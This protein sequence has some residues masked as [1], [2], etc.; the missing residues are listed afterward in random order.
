MPHA[1]PARFLALARLRAFALLAALAAL[2]PLARAAAA[3]APRPNLVY[4]LADDLGFNDCGF[5]GGKEIPTPNLDRLAASG[6][7]LDQF[8]VQPV[9]SPTRAAFMTGRYPFRYGLQVGVVRPYAPYGLALD[10]RLLP[11]AL[12]EAGYE[13]AIVGKWHL[14]HLSPAY[15]PT[16]R[17]FDHQY[18]HYN[19]ALDYFTH[20][21]DGGHDWHRDDQPNYDEGYSTQLV[22]RE[23]SRLIR[24]RDRTKPLFLYVPFNAVHAPWQAPQETIDAVKNLTANRRTYAAMLIELDRAVGEII[25]TLEKENLLSNTLIV[26]SSDNGGPR[27]GVVTDNTPLRAGK[28]TLYEGG[29]RVA[30]CASWPGRIPAGSRIG[31]PLHMVDWYPTMLGLAG[32]SL[33]Q[34]LPLDGRDILGCLT[35]GAPSPHEVIVFNTTPDS[36]ALREGRWKLVRN[37]QIN[38]SD[39]EAPATTTAQKKGKAKSAKQAAR[40]SGTD[41]FELFDLDADP[42]E[43]TNLAAAHP[44]IV[45]RLAARLAAFNAAAA[46]PLSGPNDNKGTAPKIWGQFDPKP[47]AA[48]KPD[49][50]PAPMPGFRAA[51]PSPARPNLVVFLSDD[52]SLLDSSVYGSKDVRTPN[53]QRLATDGLTF[54][55]AF[56]ASPSC[57]PSRA[58]L[59]TGLMPARNGAEPNHS[60]PRADI[61]KLPAYLQE[62]GYEVVAF[63]KVSH[64]KHT[65]DYGFDFFAHDA[66][67]EDI[68]VSAA[69]KWLRARTSTKP[70]CFIV[71]TNWPHVPWPKDPEGND[72]TKLLVPPQHVDTVQTRDARAR[73]Y[74]AIGRMDTELGEVYDAAREVLG[75]DNVIFLH[76]SDHGAQWPFGK[77]NV[78]DAGIRTPLIAVWPGHTRPGA[79]T[80][81]MVS[82]VDILP[83]LVDLGGGPAPAGIDGRSFG[84]VLR[85]QTSTHRDR[86]FATHSGDGN[87]NVYPTRALRTADWKYIRNL[88]PEYR[89]TSHVDLAQ[90]ADG[91]GYFGSWLEAAKTDPGAAEKVAHYYQRPAEEL[92]DLRAD[93][94]ELHNLATDPM[95]TPR[96]TAMREEVTAWMTEQDD[97]GR[98]FGTPKLLS[99]PAEPAASAPKDRYEFTATTQLSRAE[100]PRIAGRGFTVTVNLAA[101]A[102]G[103]GV[104]ISHGGAAHGWSLYFQQGALHFGVRRAT[105]LSTVRAEPAATATAKQ[106]AATLGTDG[107]VTLTADGRTIATGSVEGPLI[108]Q[109]V[110]VLVVG[111][112]TGGTVGEYAEPFAFTGSI[113]AATLSL[114]PSK[115]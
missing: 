114:S 36:G 29:V 41:S 53:M 9:C 102:A 5:R 61:K 51:T 73:Y 37:G 2:F 57:A 64:Y 95:R 100:S 60:K 58:A 97:P 3:P 20:Q 101:P 103:D 98:I 72:A 47:A 86:I 48:A 18:G 50:V 4:L 65:G 33:L 74:A 21:R 99:A 94:L 105:K 15:L 30:A 92:Y 11:A 54:D 32:A 10:E 80:D 8:Y 42:R 63:G 43:K 56:V 14:G 82:W 62:L 104:L 16:A 35:A 76:T 110:D 38:D 44:E 85:G 45:T 75:R 13:T 49:P 111:R 31:A 83:T 89:Y 96:L 115:P 25:A 68:A 88:H 55:R 107:R 78:Y 71:G 91:P 69:I 66:Y 67:H 52:H 109:P 27:P 34:K 81:A 7:V 24:E 22:A 79:R 28:H 108:Q 23:S 113:T 70:L 6:A 77:W 93:P 26:F 19:G 12:K 84:P 59:L 106:L 90:A 40:E 39:D 1:R 87:Y 17:G 112:D 46:K